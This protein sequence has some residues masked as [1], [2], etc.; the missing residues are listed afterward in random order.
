M[1]VWAEGER[2]P[3]APVARPRPPHDTSL[4]ADVSKLIGSLKNMVFTP[5]WNYGVGGLGLSEDLA[6]INEKQ[7]WD[8]GKGEEEEREDQLDLWWERKERKKE[9]YLHRRHW[10]VSGREEEKIA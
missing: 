1:R 7:D 5:A 6:P 8:L 2:R 4:A 10:T 3:A 9:N